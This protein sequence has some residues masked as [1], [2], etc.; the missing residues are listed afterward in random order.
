MVKIKDENLLFG[1]IKAL[2]IMVSVKLTSSFKKHLLFSSSLLNYFA[3]LL[4]S[5]LFR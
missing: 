3:I 2:N 4:G 5:K 1:W